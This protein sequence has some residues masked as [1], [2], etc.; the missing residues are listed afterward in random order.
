M[1]FYKPFKL[2]LIFNLLF[3]L[4]VF[5]TTWKSPI[6]LTPTPEYNTKYEKAKIAV[7]DTNNGLSV[8]KATAMDVQVAVLT[9]GVWG[10]PITLSGCVWE[11]S[12]DVAINDAGE[13]TVAWTENDAV[14]AA[15]FSHGILQGV[16]TISSPGSHFDVKVRI[17]SSGETIV[18]WRTL[19]G[20]WGE[21]ENI[22]AS[23]FLKGTWGSPEE[24]TH[25]KN[26]VSSIQLSL[27]EAGNA[28]ATWSESNDGE[29]LAYCA[30]YK[31]GW[32][33]P[34]TLCKGNLSTPKICL[35][36]SGDGIAVWSQEYQK[37]EYYLVAAE[38]SLTN[39]WDSPVIICNDPNPFNLQLIMNQLGN[40]LV[41]WG[42]G[43]HYDQ[44][45]VSRFYINKTWTAPTTVIESS[46]AYS[47]VDIALNNK[48]QA[49]VV[50]EED[51]KIKTVSS[52]DSGWL[53]PKTISS[54]KLNCHLDPKIAMNNLGDVYVIWLASK[55]FSQNK[56]IVQVS[57][58]K[59]ER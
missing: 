52:S 17:N 28:I 44:K 57:R 42:V 40:A 51:E 24:I 47:G 15:R 46:T 53:L 30:T 25:G 29:R 36:P 48:N 26:V 2:I 3:P 23:V 38:Y 49:V 35:D 59:I 12:Y 43:F 50:W 54:S 56:Q 34:T 9:S 33:E 13:G 16:E 20:D 1:F 6:D 19:V 41:V 55:T 21:R 37:D 4:I 39:G 31:N 5:A 58:G 45:I 11:S 22:S 7:N 8:W 27:S 18:L 14:N 32:S 10:T